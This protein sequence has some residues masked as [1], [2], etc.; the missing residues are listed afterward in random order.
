M[1]KTDGREKNFHNGKELLEGCIRKLNEN[2]KG[3]GGGNLALYPVVVIMLGEKSREH[4]QHIKNTLDDNWSN[5][6]F[7]QYL[8]VVKQGDS[9]KCRFLEEAEYYGG[10]ARWGS[11]EYDFAKGLNLAIVK[12]LETDENIFSNKKS[13]KMEFVLD[14]TEENGKEYYELFRCAKGELQ[15]NDLKTLYLMLDQNPVERCADISDEILQYIKS[16]GEKEY[17]GTIYLLS[18][19]LQSGNI[20]GKNK[21]W[22]NYRLVANIIL[23]GGNKRSPAT[24]M[25][26]GI[27]TVSYALITKPTD[28]IAVTVLQTLLK[29]MYADEKENMFY[30]ISEKE[31]REKLQITP[32]N[33]IQFIEELFQKKIA[34]N[35]PEET[36]FGYLPFRSAQDRENLKKEIKNF[37]GNAK[38]LIKMVDVRTGEALSAYIRMHFLEPVKNFWNNEREKEECRA[39]IR[40][41]LSGTFSYMELLK[42]R[43]DRRKVEEL[44][45]TEY[46]SVGGSVKE[47]ME[48]SLQA[49]SIEESKKLFYDR[50]KEVM[51]EELEKFLD[52]VEAFQGFYR[53]CEMEVAQERIVTD[54]GSESVEKVYSME[55]KQFITEN[56]KINVRESTFPEVFQVMSNKEKLIETFW[57]VFL[58]LIR[59]EAFGYNFE[60]EI[61]FRMGNMNATQRQVFVTQEL[62]KMLGGSMRLK[63]VIE[64][65][66]QK[67]GCYYLINE[68]AE[69][70]RYLKQAAGNGI[71]FRLFD[72]NRTDCIEQM[73]IYNITKPEL[74]HLRD[75]EEQI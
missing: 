23:L 29:E 74:L 73:E 63:N 19:Y 26:M 40:E 17:G 59:K 62:Q 52:A 68:N 32:N 54:N 38:T 27:K 70:T 1:G 50:A 48:E 10:E 20:L 71:D 55:V 58:K 35:F 18:N 60:K 46:H 7:L 8:N 2:Q 12:M 21:I 22:Q 47:K 5:A 45:S 69:Y 25:Y 14:A 36:G 72:I 67:I 51:L 37:R 65:S 9:W 39:L 75:F 3:G 15:A 6:R 64:L 41:K 49:G 57:N 16:M 30:D 11:D 13:V 28:E 56:K 66:P 4:M 53:Q 24:G 61:A 43:E 42:L 33:G 44:L 34:G 31:I